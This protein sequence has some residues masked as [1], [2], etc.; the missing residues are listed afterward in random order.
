MIDL[1]GPWLARDAGVLAADFDRCRT[2]W[3]ASLIWINGGA[4]IFKNAV[5]K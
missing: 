1:C 2:L 5:F 3:M 4:Q